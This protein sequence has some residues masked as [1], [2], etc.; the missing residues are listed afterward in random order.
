MFCCKNH[1]SSHWRCSVKKAVHK[2]TSPISKEN[3]YWSL[4]LIKL[5]A[6]GPAA[7]LKETPTQV[8]SCETCK[9]F[10]NIYFEEYVWTTA[11]MCERLLLKISTLQKK[12][13]IDFF[14]K[15]MTF[16]IITITFKALK[17]LLS[18]CVVFAT[19]FYKNIHSSLLCK[20]PS[21]GLIDYYVET[22][23][24]KI[25]HTWI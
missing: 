13:F 11:C 4:F 18:F 21:S 8:C 25:A 17:F 10:K 16:I 22:F 6:W 14:H 9:I 2:K 15:I 20:L 23:F 24:T 19:L 1:R 3:T 12:L 7:L 5:R